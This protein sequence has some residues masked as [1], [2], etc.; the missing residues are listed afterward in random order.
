[1]GIENR[2]QFNNPNQI[3]ILQKDNRLCPASPQVQEE[4]DLVLW[5]EREGRLDILTEKQRPVIEERY[6]SQ[7]GVVVSFGLAVQKSQENG[8]NITRM[9][10]YFSNRS[11]I[12]KLARVSKGEEPIKGGIKKL[13]IDI[14]KM[15]KML[16]EGRLE[17]AVAK[18]L[19]CSKTTLVRRI[20]RHRNELGLNIKRGR[21]RKN[22][23][24]M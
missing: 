8:A 2:G 10:L 17:E 11:A 19:G 9:A 23:E 24:E 5:A 6:L 14:N 7:Q 15:K 21:P 22:R 20:R 3:V 4:R 18:E 1:M 13:E 16:D 12:A